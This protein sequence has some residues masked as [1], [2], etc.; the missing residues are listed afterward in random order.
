[1]PS[2]SAQNIGTSVLRMPLVR[3]ARRVPRI[4]SASS[5]KM[6]GRKPSLAF[7]RARAKSSRTW[8]SDSPTHMLRISGPLTCMKYSRW[9]WPVFSR[10]WRV[11]L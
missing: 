6:K 1:M 9:S 4:D 10:S 11:R 2:I 8:R 5:M 3:P 7:S